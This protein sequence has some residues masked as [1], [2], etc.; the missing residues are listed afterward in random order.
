MTVLSVIQGAASRLTLSRPDAIVGVADAGTAQFLELLT[1][2]CEALHKDH[3]WSALITVRTFTA[4]AG[5]PQTG[6][7]PAAF[8]RLTEGVEIW[9][10]SNNWA[11]KGPIMPSDW[12]DLVVR[13]VSAGPA[14]YWRNI[15][16]VLNIFTGVAG[17]TH[18]YEYVS[19]N[20]CFT[21]GVTPASTI[22]TD[23]DTFV[24]PEELLKIAV[25]WRWKQAKALDYAEDMSTY[26][27]MKMRF[28]LQDK[29]GTTSFTTMRPDDVD[30]RAVR[31]TWPGM[32]TP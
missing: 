28:I 24:F 27:R 19:K 26:E 30:S 2:E 6:E 10:T 12:S 13:S 14:Q 1:E 32:V 7:F 11:L 18:R 21:G 4:I 8:A 31:R 20:W 9:N 25:R 3:D 23:D 17:E 16:G 22:T 29:G 15:G 5:L